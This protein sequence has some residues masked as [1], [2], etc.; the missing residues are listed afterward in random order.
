MGPGGHMH[1]GVHVGFPRQLLAT[2]S[3]WLEHEKWYLESPQHSLQEALN[4]MSLAMPETA[5]KENL[6]T[7]QAV[8]G[9]V[10][11]F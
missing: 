7:K 10:K 11:D 3:S 2:D 6:T 8:L 5:Y 9:H 4:Q 1:P